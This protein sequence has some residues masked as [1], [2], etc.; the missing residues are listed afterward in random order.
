EEL[1]FRG[2]LQNT[3]LKKWQNK[4]LAIWVT[5]ILFSAMH[6]QFFGFIPRMILG[7]FFGYLMVFTG[8]IWAPIIGH[9]TN[10]GLAVI[11]SFYVQKNQLEKSIETMGS[12]ATDWQVL[13]TSL[14][15]VS[16]FV[17]LIL[18]QKKEG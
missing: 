3:F 12:S 4:H 14:I 2:F 8:S 5:A 10:N 16:G 11:I 17:Y 15:L 1:F 13:V 7:A 9:L 6:L 18:R